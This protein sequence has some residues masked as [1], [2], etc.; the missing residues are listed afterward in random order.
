M[1]SDIEELE[2]T[3]L[4]ANGGGGAPPLSSREKLYAFLEAKTIGGQR[5]ETFV[6]V[7]I[8]VNVS[9]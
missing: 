8:V 3:P 7:L 6:I 2:T 1:A 5:Y 4:L 9:A